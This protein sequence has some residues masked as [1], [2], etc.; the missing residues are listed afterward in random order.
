[1]SNARGHSPRCF[2]RRPSLGHAQFA[3][4]CTTHQRP[5]GTC[6]GAASNKRKCRTHPTS[7]RALSVGNCGQ[8]IRDVNIPACTDH[9]PVAVSNIG[10]HKRYRCDYVGIEFIFPDGYRDHAPGIGDEEGSQAPHK[11]GHP[12]AS[13]RL[14]NLGVYGIVASEVSADGKHTNWWGTSEGLAKSWAA[15]GKNRTRISDS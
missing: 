4:R 1:M 10:Q 6:G 8:Q 12:V 11:A 9:S 14:A 13:Y 3:P 5:R 15:F 2:D 7:V